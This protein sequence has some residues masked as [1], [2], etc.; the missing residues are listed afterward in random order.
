[1]VACS[2]VGAEGG[3]PVV[4]GEVADAVGGDAEG[5]AEQRETALRVEAVSDAVGGVP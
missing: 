5:R 3:V 4:V 2:L 1:M